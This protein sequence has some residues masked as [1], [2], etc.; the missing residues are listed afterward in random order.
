MADEQD[1]PTTLEPPL[2]DL[3][4][5]TPRRPLPDAYSSYEEELYM[6][7]I[8]FE[9]NPTELTAQRL[10]E[11]AREHWTHKY[12]GEVR[13]RMAELEKKITANF[14]KVSGDS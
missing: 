3:P 13:G 14:K 7:V 11:I 9:R 2:P 10:R 12:P 8:Y 6:H 5:A 1:Q 4:P